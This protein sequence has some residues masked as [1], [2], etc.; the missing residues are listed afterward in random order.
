MKI[1]H[2]YGAVARM[3]G[4]TKW[5]LAF[6]SELRNLGEDSRI[7]CTEFGIDRPYWLS[8]PIETLATRGGTHPQRRSITRLVG[9]YARVIALA[10]RLP[11]DADAVVLHSES[12]LWV[13]PLVRR[14]CPRAQLV[15]YCYQPPRELYDLW[16]VAKADLPPATRAAVTLGRPAYQALDRWLVRRA[17]AVLVWSDEYER[18]ARAIYGELRYHHVPAG[19][20]FGMFERAD[21]AQR[22]GRIRAGRARVL[23]M[24][25]TLTRKK[26]VDQFVQVLAELRARGC[27]AHGVV[28]GEG[29]LEA[30]L[31]E[32]ARELGVADLLDL[33]GYVSQE[34]LPAYYLAADALL[35]LELAGAWSMSIIEAGAAGI[36]VV[37]APGGSMP[38][39]VRDRETG[40][41][42]PQPPTTADVADRVAQLLADDALRRRMGAANRAHCVQFSLAQSARRFVDILRSGA[43]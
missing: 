21:L 20:D 8:A 29:P 34:D 14:R 22:A 26:N 13:A 30:E 6:A 43:A 10:G 24:N 35:Y 11:A 27:P 5:L 33:A 15:Y 3:H 16:D 36:P 38:T 1:V 18:Y 25:A 17:D 42:L 39:L 41:V 31:R 7:L 12:S 19:V 4:A 32:R 28:I 23:L 40:F 9:N 37:V 2:V